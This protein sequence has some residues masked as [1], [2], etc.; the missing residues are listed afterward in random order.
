MA[1]ANQPIHDHPHHLLGA[2]HAVGRNLG[3]RVGH[4]ENGEAHAFSWNKRSLASLANRRQLAPER[5]QPS[6]S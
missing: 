4:T 3:E 2:A 1:G 6:C 5:G